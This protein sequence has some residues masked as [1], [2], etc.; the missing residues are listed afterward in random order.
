MN[1]KK[2]LPHIIALALTI[3]LLPG[4]G[5]RPTEP[6]SVPAT[7]PPAAKGAEAPAVEVATATAEAEGQEVSQ[8]S[9]PATIIELPDGTRCSF[10]GA[11]AALTFEGKRLN[12]TC[13]VEGQE[14]GL[15]GDLQQ[16]EGAWRVEKAIIGH[17]D[18]GFFLAALEPV[19]MT[20][21]RIELADGTQC[22]FAGAGTTLAFDGKRLNYTCEV[23]GEEVGLLG[24]LW[25]SEGVWRAE[26][27]AIGHGDSGFFLKES[28]EAAIRVMSGNPVSSL[29]NPASVFCEEH[30]GRVEIRDTD[31]GEVGWCVFPDGRECEEW[32]FF[33]GECVVQSIYQLPSSEM[34]GDLVDAL[35][36]A[37]GMAVTTAQVPFQDYISGEIGGGWQATRP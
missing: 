14:V 28:E 32:A 26:K 16:S 5:G 17:G 4:C 21:A 10:A 7:T 15:L 18:S 6:V 34:R 33:R 23:E 27:A 20:I 3:W 11:G 36:Q 31:G 37:L 24:D 9:Q 35:S 25:Q 30:A 1:T 8:A 22:L 29:A 2:L 12:Y 13:E 19:D